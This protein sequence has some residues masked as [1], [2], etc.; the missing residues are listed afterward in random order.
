M[1][2]PS[3]S[4][5][6]ALGVL[7]AERGQPHLMADQR[8]IAPAVNITSIGSWGRLIIRCFCVLAFTFELTS[9]AAV[10]PAK[11]AP[12]IVVIL[13]DDQGWNQVGYHGFEYYRTPHIDAIA[14]DGVWFR[15][16]YA[17]AAIC[18][19]TRAALL[20]GKSPARLNI[21]VQISTGRAERLRPKMKLVEP[22][23]RPAL[24]LEETT[25]AEMLKAGGYATGHF[26]KW[27]LSTD[28]EYQPG[29]IFYP[30]SQGFDDVLVQAEPGGRTWT[31]DAHFVD[32]ITDRTIRFIEA[33]AG[34]PFFAYV[35]HHVVHQPVYSDPERVARWKTRPGGGNPAHHPEMG[36]MIEHMDEGIGRILGTLDRLGLADGTVVVFTS[37]NGGHAALQSQAPLR[38][39]K[40]MLYEGGIRV[41]MAMRYPGVIPAG[42]VSDQ[43]VVTH[44]LFTTLLDFARIPYA[45]DLQDGVSLF[46]LVTGRTEKL[47]RDALYWHFPNYH[48]FS[49]APAGAVRR[50]DYKLIEWF[51]RSL[52][53]QPGAV[54]LYN[55]SA[56]PGEQHDLASKQPALAAELLSN[57]QS[58]RKRVGAR[59]MSLPQTSRGKDSR[60]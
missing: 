48:Q 11:R 27:H 1:I 37:D 7:T 34:R 33:N 31:P 44:D 15:A 20:T 14:R 24:P 47:E 43:L 30:G 16:A 26:G 22:M 40:A 56:D 10:P 4:G 60:Q 12:N 55:L 36:A 6:H 59:E 57:L 19:P 51:E 23:Q 18:S 5:K 13:S 32:R 17:S 58:W 9:W 41:P 29:R 28:K 25:L 3:S 38:G 52:Q 2:W 50:G 42:R 45:A 49:M 53:G 21:T 39:G 46:R 35:A 54:E 8:T